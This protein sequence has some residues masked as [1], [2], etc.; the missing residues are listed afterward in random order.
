MAI[1]LPPDHVLRI[2][3]QG[4]RDVLAAE[5]PVIAEH[6]RA[7]LVWADKIFSCGAT[8]EVV[9]NVITALEHDHD[10]AD[11]A[12]WQRITDY[13]RDKAL[14]AAKYRSRSTATSRNLYDDC[15]ASEWARVYE[16]LRDGKPG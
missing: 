1:I 16:I 8:V 15:E 6:P 13:C 7:R 2:R 12:R 3:L 10:E 5:L 9:G 11:D 14:H 4:A